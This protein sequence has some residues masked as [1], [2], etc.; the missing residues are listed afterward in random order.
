[1]YKNATNPCK[2]AC[3][4]S[5]PLA[6][7]IPVFLCPSSPR[8]TNPFIEKNEYFCAGFGFSNCLGCALFGQVLVGASDYVGGTGYAGTTSLAQAY[9]ALTGCQPQKSPV[10]PINIFE[11]NVGVD[12]IVDGTST[13]ILIAELAGRPDWW[14]RAGKQ[15][16]ATFSVNDYNGRT[17]H[18]NW[19]GCWDCTENAFMEMGGSNFAGTS[20]SV[21]AGTPVCMIN[22]VNAW[23]ANYFS[24]HPGTC[25]FVMCDGSTHFLSENI[26][27]VV[28][29][30]LMTYR[31][32]APVSDSQL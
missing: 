26:S 17:Q 2:D 21:P 19:G 12:K 23:A 30:R 1:L 7:V 3:S 13:T 11:F 24:F 25:G 8:N 20:K 5:R 6:Q 29:A 9:L 31:G 22:C 10:G 15:N 32:Y 18:L 28:L 16:D 14:T 4:A 27:L